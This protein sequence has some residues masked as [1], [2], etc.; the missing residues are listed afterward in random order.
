MSPMSDLSDF[1]RTVRGYD[2]AEVDHAF[3]L[4]QRRLEDYAT[5]RATTARQVKQLTDELAAANEYTSRNRPSFSELGTAFEGTLRI[6]EEQSQKLF[7]DATA[8][9]TRILNAA[10]TRATQLT[11]ESTLAHDALLLDANRQSEEILR[12]AEHDVIALRRTATER[13]EQAALVL[14]DA[15]SSAATLHAEAARAIAVSKAAAN[16]EIQQAKREVAELIFAAEQARVDTDSQIRHDLESAERRRADIQR[17]ADMYAATTVDH[18]NTRYEEIAAHAGTLAE[19]YQTTIAAA[20]H[21]DEAE[22]KSTRAYADR[23]IATTLSRSNTLAQDTEQMLGVLMADAEN[24]VTDLRRQQIVLHN[25]MARLAV[26]DDQDAAPSNPIVYFTRPTAT[27][28]LRE[29]TPLP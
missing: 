23:I 29:I 1:R 6:A 9:A 15:D 13:K 22:I 4:M 5:E 8:D 28:D 18:A 10:H 7:A 21:R 17:Q 19:E 12:T 16:L 14:A 27:P 24:Q 25:Y 2:P 20:R 3:E 26:A 11:E